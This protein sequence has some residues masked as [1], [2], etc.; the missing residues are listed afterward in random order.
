MHPKKKLINHDSQVTM[1]DQLADRATNRPTGRPAEV[2]PPAS[3]GRPGWPAEVDR[4]LDQPKTLIYVVVH[5]E[6]ISSLK[7]AVS[8]PKTLKNII[9]IFLIIFS[10]G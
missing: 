9:Y 8:L 7:K 2:D 6:L 1:T 10:G 3:Q 5:G 4:Q